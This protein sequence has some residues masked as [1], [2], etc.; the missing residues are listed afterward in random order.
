VI[1][2]DFGE[3]ALDETLYSNRRTEM[4][5][6]AAGWVRDVGCLPTRSPSCGAT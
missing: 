3:N 4:W 1:G 5:C 6:T 2:V